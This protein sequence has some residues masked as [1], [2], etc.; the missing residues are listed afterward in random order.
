MARFR[1]NFAAIVLGSAVLASSALAQQG[2]SV[3]LIHT[4]TV[5]V[6]PRVKVQVAPAQSIATVRVAGQPVANGMS[7]SVTAT[8]P[9]TL[10]IGAVSTKAH[11]LWSRDSHSDFSAVTSEQ[12][13]IAS[14]EI[15]QRPT[16]AN[17]FVRPSA[18][19]VLSAEAG[20]SDSSIVM[21]TMVAQ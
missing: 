8:Q 4:V 1:S 16:S 9:W 10:S 13:I 7:L 6:P 19:K 21:L 3:S 2:G 12:A 5:T 14:G 17:V 11:L 18:T 20:G 15:S